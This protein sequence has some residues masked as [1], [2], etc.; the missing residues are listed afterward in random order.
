MQTTTVSEKMM[1][2]LSEKKLSPS[3]KALIERILSRAEN[4][5]VGKPRRKSV[6]LL[7]I[8]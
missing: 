8:W 5:P 6:R 1:N 3:E 4:K 2:T 7:W